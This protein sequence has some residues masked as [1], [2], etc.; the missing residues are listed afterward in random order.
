M[1]DI[2]KPLSVITENIPES[3]KSKNRWVLWRYNRAK[4]SSSSVKWKKLPFSFNGELAS[5]TNPAT[6][7]SFERACQAY[8]TG[9]FSGI[10]FVLGEGVHGIDLD[11]CIDP[12]TGNFNE[13]AKKALELVQGYAEISPSGTGVKIYA[14]TNLSRSQTQ[15]AN[16]WEMYK[17]KRYF[18]VTGHLIPSHT[19]ISEDIQDVSELLSYLGK[20]NAG[21]EHISH[22][23]FAS[24]KSPHLRLS[25]EHI[26]KE[27]LPYFNGDH[28][29]DWIRMGMAI[30]DETDGSPEGKEA[31]DNWS[32]KFD[33]YEQG[34]CAEKWRSF[35]K[36]SG[37]QPVTMGSFISE[38]RSQSESL[39][40]ATSQHLRVLS[41]EELRSMPPQ[42]WLIKGIIPK[43]G[44][45]VIFGDSGAGKTF[46]TLDLALTVAR[47]L[48]W[49]GRRVKEPVGVLYVS[50][51]GG[52][53]MNSRINAY[54]SYH[55]TTLEEAPFGIVITSVNLRNGDA[56]RVIDACHEMAVRGHRVGL[57]VFDT[58][59]RTIG[60]GDENSSRDMGE[61]LD[62]VSKISQ[63][64][65]AFT[66]IVHHSGK[67]SQKGARGHSSLR[68]AVDAEFEVKVDGD[69]QV[70]KVTKS[71]DGETGT[72]YVYKRE[73]VKLGLDEDLEPIESCVAIPGDRFALKSN[74]PK[75]RG[76]WQQLAYDAASA[77]GDAANER[78]VLDEI[79][80]QASHQ[81][82]W[83]ENAKRGIDGC[84]KSGALILME[85]R[86]FPA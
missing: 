18:C 35:G 19:N 33:G 5:A 63:E 51:E 4:G 61:Y 29:D 7:T 10:G 41:I 48:P 70:L 13:N 3:L 37:G 62:A 85:G 15:I 47:R 46:I 75:P 78:A 38:L 50:A 80:K 36:R 1:P 31:W 22:D 9:N 24:L 66:L 84:I 16:G 74:K 65:A 23:P 17:D 71:R 45:G 25:L 77:L 27:I 55:G 82:R 86:L 54:S 72:E 67:D 21:F 68:A 12:A 42:Q 58:L 39:A 60:G 44:M 43:T 79:G 14:L 53:A 56:A 73:I 8:K 2:P 57:I 76:E 26:E 69:Q 32:I 40:L 30:H 11:D 52:S 49:Q 28:Y 6:W 20:T 64:T 81:P 83:R 34:A 59:N